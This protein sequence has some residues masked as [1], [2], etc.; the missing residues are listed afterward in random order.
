MRTRTPSGSSSLSNA[1]AP[2]AFTDLKRRRFL[3]PLRESTALGLELALAAL[4]GMMLYFLRGRS[5]GLGVLALGAGTHALPYALLLNGLV[6]ASFSLAAAFWLP[7]IACGTYQYLTVWRHFRT[8]D[9][10]QRRLRQQM[11]FVT[12]EM[13]SPLTTIAG[14]S[15]LGS[16][17]ALDEKRRQQMFE[18]IHRESQRL[19]RMVERF[20]DVERLSA[21]E[22]ELRREPVDVRAIVETS[23]ERVRPMAERYILPTRRFSAVVVSGVDPLEQTGAAVLAHV[24]RGGTDIR[25]C[26]TVAS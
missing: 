17:Y 10:T 1:A 21:G 18:L 20:L 23:A 8:A 12:H 3:L 9:A 25:V 6:A 2:S 11:E 19:S 24:N 5:L 14:S 16:K 22:I 13:R 15:E 4:T 26:V 7:L